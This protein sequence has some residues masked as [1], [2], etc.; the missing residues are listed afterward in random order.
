MSSPREQE[1]ASVQILGVRVDCVDFQQTLDIISGWIAQARTQAE[2]SE[3][4]VSHASTLT[5]QPS[6]F[7]S[8]PFPRQ[9]CTVNPEFIMTARR[10]PAFAQALAA[11]DLCTPDGVGVL[12]A[13]RLAGIH[14]AER[15]TGSDG[16][17]LI[18][19]RAAARGWRVFFLGAAPG[20]AERA[21][22]EL[23]RLY[24][25]LRVAGTYAG[26]PADTD[27]PQ[28]RRRLTAAHPDLLF[29]AYGHPRQDI[30]IHQHREALPV[31][32]ALG[33]GG[34]FDFV[35]GVTPRAPLWLRRLGLEWLYRLVRQPWRW[36]RMAALPLFALL[37]LLAWARRRPVNE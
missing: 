9:V 8:P 33:V 23:A 26:S 13:A 36:R 6:P 16:I 19:E 2:E 3:N 10:Q 14:L 30:W 37:V 15:V 35:A 11:A 20:I 1:R 5:P 29:V 22:V 17:H 24:P 12:W 32:V 21:A 34:A 27:W 4:A 28:I 31:A 18:C 7:R 25:G